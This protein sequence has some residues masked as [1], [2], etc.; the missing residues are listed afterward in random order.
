MKVITHRYRESN[1][2]VRS[3]LINL[4][5]YNGRPLESHVARNPRE[6]VEISEDLAIKHKVKIIQH[7]SGYSI[8]EK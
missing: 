4:V 6:K 8:I 2:Y 1:K 5:D 7:N 3:Y